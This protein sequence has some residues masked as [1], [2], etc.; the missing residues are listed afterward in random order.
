MHLK[1]RVGHRHSR[2]S[3]H[4]NFVEDC[5]SLDTA[6]YTEN[7]SS[8]CNTHKACWD[9]TDAVRDFHART[10][11]LFGDRKVTFAGPR[12]SDST[13]DLVIHLLVTLAS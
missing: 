3:G 10:V 9:A 6:K 12:G 2:T 1:G 8:H 4:D 7:E 11:C 13:A 5:R